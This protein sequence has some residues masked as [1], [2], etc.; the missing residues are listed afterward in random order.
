[1]GGRALNKFNIQTIRLNKEDYFNVWVEIAPIFKYLFE[2][3]KQWEEY[4]ILPRWLPSADPSWFGF[5]L[6]VR[7]GA[8]FTRSDIIKF[9]QSKKVATR[10]LFAGNI[11]KQPYFIER[12]IQFRC[13]GDLNNTDI[14]MRNTFWIGCYPGITKEMLNY[15]VTCFEEFLSQY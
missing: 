14:A 7:E 15:S 9:L 4:F 1:M 13:V 12:N 2:H 11:T 3:F 6:T 5:L 10:L 8:G